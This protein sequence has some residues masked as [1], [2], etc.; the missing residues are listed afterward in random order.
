MRLG[1]PLDGAGK[2]FYGLRGCD[3]SRSVAR[4]STASNGAPAQNAA[5]AAGAI[6]VRVGLCARGA[7][8]DDGRGAQQFIV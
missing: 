2:H 8:G 5:W 6:R 7:A 3:P 4:F 1:E